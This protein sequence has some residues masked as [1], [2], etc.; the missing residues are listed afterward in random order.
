MFLFFNLV[1]PCLIVVKIEKTFICFAVEALIYAPERP[2]VTPS[3]IVLW[4]IAVGT[5][6]CASLRSGYTTR[7]QERYNQL[8]PKVF[9]LIISFIIFDIQY[10]AEQ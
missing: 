7:E 5:L 10:I 6:T 3:I 4:S 2:I 9:H 1:I 8:S